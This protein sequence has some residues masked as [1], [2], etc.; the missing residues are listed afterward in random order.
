MKWDTRRLLLVK[1]LM[2]TVT[3]GGGGGGGSGQIVAY[4]GT[5]PNSDGVLPADQTKPAIAVKASS[6]TY[7]W[8]TV[9]LTWT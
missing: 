2:A 8:D 3:G 6:T 1:I 5:D 9:G 4:T 7:T